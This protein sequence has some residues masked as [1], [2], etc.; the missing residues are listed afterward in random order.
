MGKK[1]G[2]GGAFCTGEEDMKPFNE[3]KAKDLILTP[4]GLIGTI[5]GVKYAKKGDKDSGVL[6]VEWKEGFRSPLE[7]DLTGYKRCTEADLVWR[8][9]GEFNKKMFTVDEDHYVVHTMNL[10]YRQEIIDEDNEKKAA[11]EKK[12]KKKKKA[13]PAAD[14]APPPKA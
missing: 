12:K 9:V 8:D 10:E 4:L 11:A 5:L 6:W 2:K 3:F 7:K 13:P 14:G 1:K